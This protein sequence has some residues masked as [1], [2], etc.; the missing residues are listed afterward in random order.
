MIEAL[1]M[2]MKLTKLL[3]TAGI[4]TLTATAQAGV[5]TSVFDSSWNQM[6]ASSED[7]LG[8]VNKVQ[9]GWG[10]QKFDAEYLFYKVDNG[11]LS[12]GLQT[13]YDI[14][15]TTGVQKYKG[16]D[17]Y[18]GD[19]ALSFDGVGTKGTTGYSTTFEYAIDFGFLT[20]NYA[21]DTF[22]D[23]DNDGDGIDVAGLYSVT[24]WN[25]DIHFNSA[26]K[27]H[28]NSTPYAMDEGSLI[29]GVNFSQDAAGCETIVGEADESKSGTWD[30][31]SCY[32]VVSF[33]IS[34]LG[35]ADDVQFDAHWTMSCG[36]DAIDGG[37]VVTTTSVPEP[38]SIA[39]L[40][41]GMVGLAAMRKRNKQITLLKKPLLAAFFSP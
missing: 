39:L 24:A 30:N 4:A 14:S 31:K 32:R 22:I 35:L 5:I 17:Y 20:K 3:L 23:A 21:G 29:S 11:R 1:G 15:T 26:T 36:N 25:N 27:T 2:D 16:K 13:G 18:S 41:L 12:I 28:K 34:N 40:G 38:A 6:S 8:H 19:L 10:G 7:D 37:G 33:D 9:P